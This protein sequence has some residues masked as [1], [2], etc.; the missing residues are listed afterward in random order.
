MASRR[1]DASR[2]DRDRPP[3]VKSKGTK[4]HGLL[5]AALEM[6]GEL[7]QAG[8]CDLKAR[9]PD[10]LLAREHGNPV[11]LD[12][13]NAVYPPVDEK[14]MTQAALGTYLFKVD[15]A[16][17]LRRGIRPLTDEEEKRRVRELPLMRRVLDCKLRNASPRVQEAYNLITDRM[18]QDPPGPMNEHQTS[19]ALFSNARG[20]E[21]ARDV[22]MSLQGKDEMTDVFN[23]LTFFATC[24]ECPH[25]RYFPK[26][27]YDLDTAWNGIHGWAG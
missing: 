1:P 8:L 25:R 4:S 19:R 9:K 16:I 24:S 14:V 26:D 20:R 12:L 13:I 22:A 3:V 18:W 15:G 27:V 6:W 21:F 7:E 2:P 17:H 10:T 11:R 5:P 23:M